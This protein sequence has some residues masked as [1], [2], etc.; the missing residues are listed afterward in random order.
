MSSIGCMHD[1]KTYCFWRKVYS[2]SIDGNW[3][4]VNIGAKLGDGR[5]LKAAMYCTMHFDKHLSQDKMDAAF[6][7][8][9]ANGIYLLPTLPYLTLTLLSRALENYAN[10]WRLVR[11]YKICAA[12]ILQYIFEHFIQ[13]LIL[14]QFLKIWKIIGKLMDHLICDVNKE[15]VSFLS[16][17][18]GATTPVCWNSC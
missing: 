7:I 5:E 14:L 17:F 10:K 9:R 2:G 13:C 8:C 3:T 12:P 16:N 11:S 4:Y 1:P 15:H 6:S 18:Q